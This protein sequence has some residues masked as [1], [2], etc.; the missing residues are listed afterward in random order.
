MILFLVSENTDRPESV[1][2]SLVLR[3]LNSESFHFFRLL[4]F[5]RQFLNRVWYNN[6]SLI[7]APLRLL[8]HTCLFGNGSVLV[9]ISS[10]GW[11]MDLRIFLQESKIYITGSSLLRF[12]ISVLLGVRGMILSLGLS[13]RRFRRFAATGMA[14]PHVLKI[15]CNNCLSGYWKYNIGKDWVVF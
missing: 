5:V 12:R 15:C 6:N 11:P 3:I 8:V 10:L 7:V 4:D 1:E 13:A 9:W 14:R 2:K